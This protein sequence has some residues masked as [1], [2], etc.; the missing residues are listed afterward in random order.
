MELFTLNSEY[1][2]A[3]LVERYGSLIWTERYSK[4][5]DFQL[6]TTDVERMLKLLPLESLIS[7]RESTVP[8]VV[9]VHKIEKSITGAPVLTVTGRSFDSVLERRVSILV[10][11][12]D[13]GVTWK[14]RT[15]ITPAMSSS[16]AAYLTIRR[17]IGDLVV[18]G[19]GGQTQLGIQSPW[20]S[21]Y[22]T[23]PMV[24]L[25][26]PADFVYVEPTDTTPN[27]QFEIKPG[28][29]YEVA[30][31]LITSNHHG[32]KSV[33]PIPGENKI[34]IEIYNGADLTN[35][36]VFDAKFDQFDGAMYLLS[37]AGS[38]NWGYVVSKTTFQQVPKTLVTPETPEPESLDRRV[39]FV[40]ISGEDVVDTVDVRR[41]R[42]LIELYK[43]NATALFDGQ[44]AE[45]VAAGYNKD[46]FL[47]D[48]IRLDGEYGLSENVRVSEF[49]RSDDNT[50][51][52]AYPT[53]EVIA[54]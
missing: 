47:G 18:R 5:G 15:W 31:E 42:G 38:T 35:T 8:M 45:Q 10:N 34:A 48:I 6:V 2:L 26:L 3:D 52:K 32:L 41:T 27:R 49:I 37:K 43:Y 50:G 29:L 14:L 19:T 20:V 30:M 1:Q 16:D 4:A 51:S 25:P 11:T 33:R 13:N 39:L 28:N 40:N 9:E 22:D 53:F 12:Q 54:S 21:P 36:V 46:Y 44:I 23:L 24:D 17:T 7:L